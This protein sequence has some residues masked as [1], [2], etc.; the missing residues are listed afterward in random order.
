L[1]AFQSEQSIERADFVSGLVRNDPDV[2]LLAWRNRV[3][4]SGK[5]GGECRDFLRLR[6]CSDNRGFC[7]WQVEPGPLGLLTGAI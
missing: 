5:H 6:P 1:V 3:A 2:G 4:G 7:F